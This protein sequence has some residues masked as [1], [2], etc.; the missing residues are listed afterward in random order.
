[1]SS[2]SEINVLHHL[3]KPL[4]FLSFPISDAILYGV[5]FV[6]GLVITSLTLSSKF[7]I[8]VLLFNFLYYVGVNKYRRKYGTTG[9]WARLTYQY[10]PFSGNMPASSIREWQT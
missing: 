10:L 9:D 4:R 6:G 1:M 5:M 3:D 7:L 2:Y 8:G